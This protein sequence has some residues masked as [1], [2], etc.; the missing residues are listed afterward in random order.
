MRRYKSDTWEV[1][2]YLAGRNLWV[3]PRDIFP[4]AL[5]A[6]EHAPSYGNYPMYFRTTRELDSIGLPEGPPPEPGARRRRRRL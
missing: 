1:I 6:A 4:D 2:Y 5:A 3:R